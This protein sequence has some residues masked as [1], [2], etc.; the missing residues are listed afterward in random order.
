MGILLWYVIWKMKDAQC[1]YCIFHNNHLFILARSKH[2]LSFVRV[3]FLP[4]GNL[5][6]QPETFSYVC[7]IMHRVSRILLCCVPLGKW[8]DTKSMHKQRRKEHHVYWIHSEC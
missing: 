2:S 1:S 4:K 3:F 5:R 8:F 7:D 6:Y